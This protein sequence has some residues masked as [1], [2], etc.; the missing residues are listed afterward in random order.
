[1]SGKT[2]GKEIPLFPLLDEFINDCQKGKRLK[3]NGRLLRSRTIENYQLLRSNLLEFCERS[4]LELRFRVL[5]GKNKQEFQRENR[6]W[7][8]FYR[9]YTDFL[10]T[11]KNQYDNYVGHQVKMIRSFFNYVHNERGYAIGNFHQQFHVMHEEVQIVALSPDR[12]KFLIY[13]QEFDQQLEPG[14]KVV[15]D[16]F[17]FGCTVA[18]R[19]SDLMALKQSDL[20]QMNGETY[21]QKR[22]TK[23]QAFTRVKLPDYCIEIIERYRRPGGK[24][25]LPGR[26]TDTINKHVKVICEKAGWTE[27]TPKLRMKRGVPQELYLNKKT[28]RSYRFC[29]LVTSHTMR[30]T[31]ITTYLAL[32]VREEI[33]RGISGHAPGSKEFWRY[34]KYSQMLVDDEIDAVHER[35][36]SF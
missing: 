34:V 7:K 18:L 1:M 14:E 28:K 10:Y 23:T 20:V 3:S 9:K 31:G 35:L 16:I 26:H 19:V 24:Q 12:L 36:K 17:V 11:R 15:K 30:R 22:S 27:P 5:S 33:V 21:L 6:Y 13:D 2:A 4:G 25:L 29:D 8:N 32:G